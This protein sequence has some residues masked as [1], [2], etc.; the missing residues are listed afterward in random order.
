MT[1]WIFEP[2]PL[3]A[4]APTTELLKSELFLANAANVTKNGGI[5]PIG[6]ENSER[7]KI[8][9]EYGRRQNNKTHPPQL[10][11][12]LFKPRCPENTSH[13]HSR[14]RQFFN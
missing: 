4:N 7:H 12:P 6:V 14:L 3:T 2:L 9:Y 5:T 11:T 13:F 1:E 8:L 10:R